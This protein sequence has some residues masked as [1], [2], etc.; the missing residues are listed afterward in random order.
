MAT[1]RARVRVSPWSLKY[2]LATANV[3]VWTYVGGWIYRYWDTIE[4]IGREALE[5]I[6]NVF[7]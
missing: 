7:R 6:D 4:G 5:C 3:A 1:V 2:T